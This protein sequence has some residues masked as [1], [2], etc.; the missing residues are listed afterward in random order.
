[1]MIGAGLIGAVA[2]PAATSWDMPIA[3]TCAIALFTLV[4]I[5][6]RIEAVLRERR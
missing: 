1:M 4:G 2:I 6:L 5:G 3:G